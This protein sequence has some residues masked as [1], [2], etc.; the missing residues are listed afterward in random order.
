M[1]ACALSS[2][3]EAVALISEEIYIACDG[4]DIIA[5]LPLRKAGQW[6]ALQMVTH[7]KPNILTDLRTANPVSY[8]HLVLVC[9]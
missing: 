1:T 8:T 4:V 9:P 2:S 3:R 5:G 7:K 6:D